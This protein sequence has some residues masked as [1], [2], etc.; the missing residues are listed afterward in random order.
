MANVKAAVIIALFG[1]A[2][3]TL[4]IDYFMIEPRESFK[5]SSIIT[6][7]G[8]IAIIVACT[9]IGIIMALKKKKKS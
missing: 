4:F 8:I 5:P 2:A 3:A 6:Q 9:M 1:F 7:V